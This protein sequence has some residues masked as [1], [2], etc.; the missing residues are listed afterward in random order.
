MAEEETSAEPISV[1]FAG[2]AWWGAENGAAHKAAHLLLLD[3][4]RLDFKFW[5]GVEER[6][7]IAQMCADCARVVISHRPQAVICSVG[8]TDVNDELPAA[9][10]TRALAAYAHDIQTK[11]RCRV[12][13]CA[14]PPLAFAPVVEKTQLAREYDEALARICDA[15][16]FLQ[17]RF[18]EPF[19]SFVRLQS[20]HSG[21]LYP[22]HMGDGTLSPF[23]QLF[24]ARAIRKSDLLGLGGPATADPRGQADP[25]SAL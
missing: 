18:E 15:N 17:L 13:F 5:Y 16:G 21:T 9:D 10:F 1:V 22:L 24:V 12:L 6:N 20:R 3:H 2:D 7:S 14:P 4:P 19:L 8:F 11:C 25:A 23:G